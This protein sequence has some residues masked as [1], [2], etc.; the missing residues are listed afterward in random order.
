MGGTDPAHAE[1]RSNCLR[2]LARTLHLRNRSGD[3]DRAIDL[4]LLSIDEW[5]AA[6]DVSVYRMARPVTFLL[7]AVTT[8]DGAP[9]A[10][11]LARELPQRLDRSLRLRAPPGP[12]SASSPRRRGDASRV[13]PQRTCPLAGSVRPHVPGRPS[14][15]SSCTTC[16][17]SSIIA[18]RPDPIRAARSFSTTACCAASRSVRRGRSAGACSR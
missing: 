5:L 17:G 10:V 7:D 1:A 18:G 6:P 8:R 9:A 15:A 3:L 11:A 12:E 2:H 14:A 13:R 16:A 4:Y